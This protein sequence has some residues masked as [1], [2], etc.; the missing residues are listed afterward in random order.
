MRILAALFLLCAAFVSFA[1]SPS[2]D[3]VLQKE[4]PSLEALYKQLHQNPELSYYEVKTSARI[5]DELRKAGFEVAQDFGQYKD[6]QLVSHG[7]VAVL[8]NGAGPTVMV[9]TDLDALP[10]PD[11]TGAPYASTAT[12]KNDAGESVPVTHGCGHDM[13]MT[14]FV[15][16]ARALSAMRDQWKGTLI[17]I[18]QPAE[19]RAPGGAEALLAGGLY[20]KFPKPDY[21][22]ALHNHAGLE[23]GK[24]GYVEGYAL[25]GA[26]SPDILIKGAGGH[27]AYPYTTKDP[28]V[29]AA[30]TVVALQTI[31]SRE[32]QAG[33]PAVVTVGSMHAGTK[34]NI[35]P[36]DAR[37]EL[38]VRSY[39]KN[40]REK[41]LSSIE[42]IA[43]GIAMAGGGEAVVDL[44]PEAYV[45]AV[46]NNPELVK[47]SLPA[48]KAA[49]GDGNVV[50][51]EPV[52]G[53]EDFS[54][55]SLDDLSVPCF[56]FWLGAVDPAK[57]AESKAKGTQLPSLHSSLFAPAV[58]TGIKTGVKAM[59]AAVINLMQ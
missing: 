2:V 44:H 52:M 27:G 35:I 23:T 38:T 16:T 6:P 32:V 15:G 43:K 53:A 36:D 18:G 45:P 56:L 46:Y 28:V 13:H 4:Y 48:L 1:Q 47:R 55:Y 57:L 34:R 8:R 21:V 31:V 11:K 33:K 49:L 14:V 37:L 10:M 50:Q 54:H 17:M 30:E 24:V 25:A 5:A 42:R 40:V 59:T 12:A 26:D 22:L 9:R 19:E 7:V 39:E 3:S 20:T 41:V 58:D 51:V 29:M